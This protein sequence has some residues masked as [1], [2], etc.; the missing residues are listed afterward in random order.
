VLSDFS[1]RVGWGATAA[2]VGGSAAVSRARLSLS[3]DTS[4]C[5]VCTAS[6]VTS[7]VAGPYAGSGLWLRFFDNA[8]SASG[9]VAGVAAADSTAPVGE[10][11]A[12]SG[13]ASGSAVG[14]AAFALMADAKTGGLATAGLDGAAA[15]VRMGIREG[16]GRGAA[17]EEAA[18]DRC[19]TAVGVDW[20]GGAASSGRASG[21][22][23]TAALA[24]SAD[25]GW[26]GVT[27]LV[28]SGAREEAECRSAGS[29]AGGVVDGEA[30][31]DR[32]NTV[33]GADWVGGVP[34]PG[35]ASGS[36]GTAA[37]AVISD[38]GWAGV[39]AL[40]HSGAR[41]EAGS[42][43]AGSASGAVLDGEAMTAGSV[44]RGGV[45]WAIVAP[46]GGAPSRG[47]ASGS[48]AGTVA[49][50]VISGVETEGL[51]PD[52][53]AWPMSA[54]A[55]AADGLA[56]SV[57]SSE[58]SGQV[59]AELRHSNAHP[60]FCAEAGENMPLLGVAVSS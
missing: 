35:R 9:R 37:L 29:A 31:G 5:F 11:D 23:G 60:L 59:T 16:A 19:N 28:H 1:A 36:A 8:D 56:G 17:D 55:S 32:C 46:A 53:A 45:V 18:G 22:A 25:A 7:A 41:E 30:A 34:S 58:P 13:R 2:M 43:S 3:S 21:S 33:G 52:S 15:A 39:T 14:T 42:P 20:V 4:G 40:V 26:A 49:F 10:G 38:A 24:V 27:A 57:V 44:A 51:A 54:S 48:A 47:R 50:A 12:S 6:G